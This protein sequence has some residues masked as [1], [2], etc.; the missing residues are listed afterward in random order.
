MMNTKWINIVEE[1][2][3]MY[4]MPFWENRGLS[5]CAMMRSDVC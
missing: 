1:K 2:E 5:A 4:N 3:T